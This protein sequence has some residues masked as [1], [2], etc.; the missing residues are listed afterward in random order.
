MKNSN[1]QFT[2][3]ELAGLKFVLNEEF[4]NVGNE[5]TVPTNIETQ[6]SPKEVNGDETI[7]TVVIKVTIGEEKESSPYYIEV[8]EKANFKWKTEDFSDEEANVLLS[9]NA[10]SLL[11][12][13]VRPII[14]NVTGQTRYPGY[15]LPFINVTAQ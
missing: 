13:Y 15:N 14:H 12:S 4:A 9:Q 7:A 2:T 3:P 1:F 10:A 11:I 6:V 8:V 5:V